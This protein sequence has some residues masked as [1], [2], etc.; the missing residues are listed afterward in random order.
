MNCWLWWDCF[1]I[2]PATDMEF[3]SSCDSWKV[4]WSWRS[5]S[6]NSTGIWLKKNAVSCQQFWY[7]THPDFFLS[8]PL[9]F[10]LT[11]PSAAVLNNVRVFLVNV[12]DNKF[13]DVRYGISRTHNFYVS[14]CIYIYIYECIYMYS[15]TPEI[16]LH[17]A[18]MCW[19]GKVLGLGEKEEHLNIRKGPRLAWL[20]LLPAGS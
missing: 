13:E 14:G 18:W 12:C 5:T 10:A 2:F 8:L 20:P 16:C 6:N 15:S 1:L 17:H 11:F 4:L 19:W 3:L 9:F 7:Q